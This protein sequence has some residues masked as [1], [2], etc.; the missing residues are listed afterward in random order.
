MAGLYGA[1]QYSDIIGG[2]TIILIG[3]SH[4]RRIALLLANK[5]CNVKIVETVHWRV[6][7]REVD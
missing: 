6:T 3:A 1:N 7:K 5:D 2:R 4:M